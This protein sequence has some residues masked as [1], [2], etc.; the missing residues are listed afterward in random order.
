MTGGKPGVICGGLS[1]RN[2]AGQAV[3][4]GPGPNPFLTVMASDSPAR[5]ISR[6]SPNDEM[7]VK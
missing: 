4:R 6:L 5:R 2:H 3:E 7:R 1:L